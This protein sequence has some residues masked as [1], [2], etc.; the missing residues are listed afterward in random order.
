MLP[1]WRPR[2]R[3][4]EGG[5][6]PV[7]SGTPAERTEG[8]CYSSHRLLDTLQRKTLLSRQ[9]GRKNLLSITEYNHVNY[10]LTSALYI[11]DS[12]YCDGSAGMYTVTQVL[13]LNTKF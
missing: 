8:T 1:V 13:S 5:C 11:N 9:N 7:A 3:L 2:C 10:R 6:S 12:Q 4:W